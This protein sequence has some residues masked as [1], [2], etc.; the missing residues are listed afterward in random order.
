MCDLVAHLPRGCALWQE[1]GGAIALTDE[2]LLLR[3]AVYRLEVIDW[4]NAGS[5]GNA[6]KR[7]DLPKAA[8]EVR[9]AE[10]KTSA[11]A[12]KHAARAAKRAAE[13]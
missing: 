6:P 4:H 10:A 12:R 3:E 13:T 7:I 2:A 5:K 9:A 8:H 1:T 11:K